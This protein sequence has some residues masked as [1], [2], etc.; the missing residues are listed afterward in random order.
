MDFPEAHHGS[1]LDEFHAGNVDVNHVNHESAG[2]NPYY[3]SRLLSETGY[4]DF[5]PVASTQGDLLD[6]RIEAYAA[7]YAN[8]AYSP[9]PQ[10]LPPQT[11][12]VKAASSRVNNFLRSDGPWTATRSQ[13]QDIQFNATEVSLP[14]TNHIFS[15]PEVDPF[16]CSQQDSGYHSV[17]P[18]FDQSISPSDRPLDALSVQGSNIHSPD[19]SP[20]A[21]GQSIN[22]QDGQDNARSTSR[23]KS[24]AAKETKQPRGGK[25][26]CNICLKESK[27]PSDHR[28]A[29]ST[30]CFVH[31]S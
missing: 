13:F 3:S 30:V 7:S 18:S 9:L 27:C 1:I 10:V 25:R 4:S 12:F 24:A 29:R 31:L 21:T 2:Q 15:I 16:A 5:E 8:S 17:G 19:M 11:D 28:Y 6:S 20:G 14:D 26:V 22:A 23:S